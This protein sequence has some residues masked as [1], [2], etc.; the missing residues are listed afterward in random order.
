MST[1]IK[2]QEYKEI[3][4]KFLD[5]WEKKSPG[6]IET[7]KD[8]GPRLIFN[9]EGTYSTYEVA[10]VWEGPFEWTEITTLFDGFLELEDGFWLE[11][12]NGYAISIYR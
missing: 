4:K 1:K 11:T 8:H 2:K 6:L 3:F 7:Y 10:I 12:I 9:W 5:F